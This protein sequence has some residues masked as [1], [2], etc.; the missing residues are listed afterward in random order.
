MKK[1]FTLLVL[2]SLVFGSSAGNQAA[3]AKPLGWSM[4][5][6]DRNKW[7]A[8]FKKD[9]DDGKKYLLGS[10]IVLFIGTDG[11][12]EMTAADQFKKRELKKFLQSNKRKDLPKRNDPMF[13]RLV[14]GR[15]FL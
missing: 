5:Y 1:L 8:D 13:E 2:S 10:D 7:E 9:S 15:G 4:I 3:S 11:T 12:L 14:A 6:T